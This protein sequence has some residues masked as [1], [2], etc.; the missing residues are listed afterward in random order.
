MGHS[1]FYIFSLISFLL[2]IFGSCQTD[3]LSV[4]SQLTSGQYLTSADGYYQLIYQSN[5]I[6]IGYSVS[7]GTTFW[8]SAGPVSPGTAGF[9]IIQYDF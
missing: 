8:Q 5:G 2:A 3:T 4:N 6:L 7:D 9:I 1:G